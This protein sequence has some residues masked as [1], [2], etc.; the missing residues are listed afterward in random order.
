MTSDSKCLFVVVFFFY[1]SVT[2][3]VYQAF[4]VFLQLFK[5]GPTFIIVDHSQVRRHVL[6]CSRADLHVEGGN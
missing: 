3:P 1:E 4:N 2:L 6:S 5:L